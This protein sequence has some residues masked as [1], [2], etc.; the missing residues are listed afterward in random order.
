[1]SKRRLTEKQQR[2][3]SAG[4]NRHHTSNDAN[5]LSGTVISHHGRDLIA[6]AANG[7][8]IHCRLRQNIG[9]IVCG[10][11]I[12]YTVEDIGSA[13]EQAVVIALAER[14]NLLQKTGF[15]NKAKPVAANIDQVVIVCALVPKPNLYLID[16]Y[17]VATENL[18]ARP[19]LVINK[20]DLMDETSEHI[21]NDIN[22][23]YGG[24]GYRVIETS[25]TRMNG[26]DELQ[27]EL[28]G[29]TSILV[30]LSGVGKSSLIKDL[31]P[32]IDIRIGE[33]SVASQ[34]G[35]HTT[36]VSSLYLM[37][38]GGKLIDSPGV[39]DFTP[40][41]LVREEILKGFI[42]LTPYRG[43]CKFANCTHDHEP[44][45]A[46]KDALAK[47]EVSRQRVDSF[48]K[49]LADIG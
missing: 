8:T 16:R 13:D 31:L 3:I 6:L 38:E 20:T 19:L 29:K 41:N 7:E 37:P 30:G 47:G 11:R 18:P 49:M 24:I 28:S 21:V 5:T 26:L 34:E 39:R 15:G 1:M 36:T 45:C 44:G 22:A 48:R 4:K 33:I 12:L 10:D 17:L 25:A 27:C 40:V 42:E 14:D 9:S 35:K 43:R 32:E 46:I 23:I 2:L